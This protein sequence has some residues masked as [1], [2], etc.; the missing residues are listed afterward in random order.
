[1]R[2]WENEPFYYNKAALV[3]PSHA[4]NK[5]CLI[6][7]YEQEFP[8]SICRLGTKELFYFLLLMHSVKASL[9]CSW[10]G[11]LL[12]GMISKCGEAFP[13]CQ[14]H[15]TTGCPS[16]FCL[17]TSPLESLLSNKRSLTFM[18]VTQEEVCV[19]KKKNMALAVIT[20]IKYYVY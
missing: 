15:P 13:A 1:M 20:Q 17:E 9:Q 14:L 11:Y 5:A 18:C 7:C 3:T 12:Q 4:S 6:T 8:F 10:F 19:R 2:K 16:L